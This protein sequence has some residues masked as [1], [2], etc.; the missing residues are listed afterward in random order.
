[1]TPVLLLKLFHIVTAIWLISGLAGRWVV[2]AAAARSGEIGTTRAL[3]DVAGRF[4]MGMVR[5]ASVGVLLSGLGLAYMQDQPLLG[6]FQGAGANWLLVSLLLYLTSIP[7][8]VGVFLPR[9]KIFDHAL[10]DASAAGVVT[11]QL[12]AAL[13]DRVVLGGHVVEMVTVCLILT[14]MVTRF[15]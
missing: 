14:L 6:M 2:L 3:V 4:E 11:P 10:H 7:L 13:A 8:V 12:R 9:G 15:F 1:M 5:P